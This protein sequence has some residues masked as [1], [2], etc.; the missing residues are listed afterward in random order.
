MHIRPGDKVLIQAP[1]YHTFSIVIKGAGRFV[2]S[3]DLV[4]EDGR[5]E[6]NFEDLEK[7]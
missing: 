3:N 1:V 2:E 4:L 5:Y 6:M 7:K